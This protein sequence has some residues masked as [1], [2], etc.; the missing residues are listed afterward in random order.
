MC[1]ANARRTSCARTSGPGH[2]GLTKAATVGQLILET[3]GQMIL[4][5]L[6]D[7]EGMD[8]YKMWES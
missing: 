8:R 5:F 4:S 7:R 2:L 6:D 3:D 1:S